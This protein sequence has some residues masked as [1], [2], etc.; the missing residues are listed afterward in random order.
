MTLLKIT[1]LVLIA[2]GVF[3]LALTL[4]MAKRNGTFVAVKELKR[5]KANGYIKEHKE[6]RGEDIYRRELATDH[7][8]LM[9]RRAKRVLEKLDAEEEMSNKAGMG[10]GT[11]LLEE[12]SVR[13]GQSK[14]QSLPEKST[15]DEKTVPLRDIGRVSDEEK[16][17]ALST[18]EKTAALVEEKTTVLGS[19]E[20]TE[21]QTDEEKTGLLPEEGTG[22]L[23]D[24]GKTG[25]LPEEGT[26]L[27]T[28]EEK[29]G[30]LPEE[31]TALLVDDG[32]ALLKA[33]HSK[34]QQ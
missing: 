27:L 2:T 6:D 13:P 1:G 29:T 28:D 16:T 4:I 30:L 15:E 34:N 7:S 19:K 14:V 21:I 33:E 22:F 25:L 9:S 18:D 26:A 31:D 11:S 10:K 32:T 20:T 5:I 23:P 17:K 12:V 3:V 24:D 8:R